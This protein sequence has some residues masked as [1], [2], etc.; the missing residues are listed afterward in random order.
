M[1]CAKKWRTDGLDA[2]A[3]QILA[4]IA[5]KKLTRKWQEDGGKITSRRRWCTSTAGGG[6][7]AWRP[8][9]LPRQVRMTGH[10]P[11]LAMR[12]AGQKPPYVWVSDMPGC[13]LDGRT[14]CVAGDTPEL[15]DFRLRRLTAIVNGTDQPAWTASPPSARSL[16]SRSFQNVFD[17]RDAVRVVDTEE[18]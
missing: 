13:I 14:V 18:F 10:Q 4:D 11:I 15:E 17:G 16:P 7:T 12:R 9:K 6:R 1:K 3:D 8:K 2:V 5:T